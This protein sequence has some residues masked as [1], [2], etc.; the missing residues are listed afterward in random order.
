MI[1]SGLLKIAIPAILAFMVGI[2][3]TPTL[4][5][6]FYK[7][8]LWKKISRKDVS[9]N[10]EMSE[11]FKKIHDDTTETR[12]PRVGGIVVWGSVIL[13]MLIIFVMFIL[14][15][16]DVTSKLEFVS[17]NQTFLP[18]FALFVG[19]FIGLIEDLLEINST[20]KSLLHGLSGKTIILIVAILGLL[21]GGWYYFKL[22]ADFINIPIIHTQIHLGILFIPFFI[23]VTLGTFSSRVIDG[24]DGL[25]GGVFATIFAAYAVI[26]FSQ[27][28][29]DLAAFCATVTGA[30]LAFLWFNIP[31]A[32]FYMGETGMLALTLALTTVAFL[33]GQ[34]LLL[35]VIGF[36]LVMTSF[37][38]FIQIWAK[39]ILGPEK[40]KIFKI[41]PLHHHFEASGWSR[42]KITMRYWILS[43][44]CA[45][46][47]VILAII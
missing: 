37:S 7:Y 12:T 29:I 24:V 5:N 35:L 6:I 44:V 16:S 41:A 3:I 43:V 36:P 30:I 28:Q 22:G 40:G 4:T 25:S 32:R 27:N 45:T 47:G 39:K 33:T 2:F 26:A 46:T 42:P 8:K 10:P 14:F 11:A 15:P 1:T 38:S 23:L 34:V 18:L 31:P 9:T 21:M 19:A 17:R 20:D 13:T